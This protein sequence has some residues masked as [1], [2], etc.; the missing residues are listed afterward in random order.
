MKLLLLI[1]SLCLLVSSCAGPVI[2]SS[3]KCKGQGL[4]TTP[5]GEA[6]KSIQLKVWTGVQGKTLELVDVLEKNKMKCEDVGGMQMLVTQS[7]SDLLLSLIPFV[8]RK[9]VTLNFYAR[10]VITEEEGISEDN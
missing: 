2:L 7:T 10:P 9:E 8:S 6:Q 4:W 1:I 3:R 5:K